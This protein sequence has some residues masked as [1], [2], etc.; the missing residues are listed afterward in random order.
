MELTVVNV[1]KAG[2]KGIVPLLVPDRGHRNSHWTSL[3]LG[4]K[5]EIYDKIHPLQTLVLFSMIRL[6]NEVEFRELSNQVALWYPISIHRRKI[7]L[8]SVEICGIVTVD[9]ELVL[10]RSNVQRKESET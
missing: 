9:L 5:A 10:S 2:N 3:N 4:V 1:V 8:N 7:F 6:G